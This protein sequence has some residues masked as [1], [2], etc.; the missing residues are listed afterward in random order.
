[1]FASVL[2]KIGRTIRENALSKPRETKL[3]NWI[4]NTS[5]S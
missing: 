3:W 2:T 1:M 4:D 5:T